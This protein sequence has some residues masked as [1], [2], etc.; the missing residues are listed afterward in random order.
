M[1]NIYTIVWFI[2]LPCIVYGQ[3][4]FAEGLVITH[5]A[6]TINGFI[7]YKEWAKNP[8]RITFKRSLSA[9][10]Q[11]FTENDIVYFEVFNKDEAYQRFI[12]PIS[13]DRIELPG[14]SVGP[15]TTRLVKAVFLKYIEKGK[16]IDLLS[17]TDDLKSRHYIFNKKTLDEL[18]YKRYFRDNVREEFATDNRFKGQFLV[19]SQQYP[20][21]N[22]N[23]FRE[24]INKTSYLLSSIAPLVKEINADSSSVEKISSI[25][26]FAGLTA[27]YGYSV[28]KGDFPLANG[29][30]SK[31]S[32]TPGFT[33]GMDAF[34]NKRTKKLLFRNE[35]SLST[36]KAS[37]IKK[38]ALKTTSHSFEQTIVSVS[39]QVIY[40]LY[41][42]NN[43]RVN[44]GGGFSGN[45]GKTYK[46]FYKETFENPS[47]GSGDINKEDGIEINKFWFV[48]P[49]RAGLVI[50]RSWEASLIYVYPLSSITSVPYFSINNS[51]YKMGLNYL[52]NSKK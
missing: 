36:N 11:V 38:D 21:N 14:L 25:R 40:H 49:V 16:N 34:L 2:L 6:D 41:T 5:K 4:N 46:N 12:T 1:R 30:S 42:K 29:A 26:F 45:F 37:M 9:E 50:N 39:P 17:Y 15:D 20:V 19:I 7:D 48:M 28:Y 27:N 8:D 33:V 10:E 52:F 44:V 31:G 51:T 13:M 35:L 22:L 43:M 23:K 3:S 24:K 32:F 47:S 18:I